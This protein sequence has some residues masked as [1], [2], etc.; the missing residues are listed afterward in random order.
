MKQEY[1]ELCA[2]Y[3]RARKLYDAYF[4]YILKYIIQNPST[5]NNDIKNYWKEATGKEVTDITYRLIADART[6]ANH[7]HYKMP[8]DE[9]PVGI[10]DFEDG[11]VSE[12]RWHD[13][14]HKKMLVLSDIHFPYHDKDRK[15]TRLN[16]SHIPLSRMP[17]SA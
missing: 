8:I 14:K 11:L 10:V 9:A 17:S 12:L 6:V 16:S 13:A 7:L 15:S 4:E 1:I 2:S 3:G 5:K